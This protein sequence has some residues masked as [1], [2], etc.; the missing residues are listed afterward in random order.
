MRFKEYH[1]IIQSLR[2][3]QLGGYDR[4]AVV[5]DT[6]ELMHTTIDST[7]SSFKRFPRPFI[8]SIVSIIIC[9]RFRKVLCYTTSLEN[10]IDHFTIVVNQRRKTN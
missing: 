2:S 6:P 5:E 1:K 3:A 7:H 8:V 4:I 10:R 9:K